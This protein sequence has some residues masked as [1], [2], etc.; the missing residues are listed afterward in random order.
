MAVKRHVM[1]VL[2]VRSA[3]GI[4]KTVHVKVRSSGSFKS[5]VVGSSEKWMKEDVMRSCDR[6]ALS[7]NPKCNLMVR[8]FLKF[9]PL[10]FIVRALEGF[11]KG[12]LG[13]SACA[14][15]LLVIQITLCIPEKACDDQ[16]QHQCNRKGRDDGDRLQI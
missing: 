14:E 1:P 10:R 3:S 7:G 5:V 16:K 6:D 11:V 9:P 4:R 2:P 13:A 12:F 8:D 15:A